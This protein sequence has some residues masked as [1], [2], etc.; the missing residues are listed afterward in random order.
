MQTK[1][2]FCSKLV[3]LSVLPRFCYFLQYLNAMAS[4]TLEM[5]RKVSFSVLERE[6]ENE[7]KQLN[8]KKQTKRLL[9]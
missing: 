4:L 9:L 6:N 8:K 1:K 7:T 2:N 5:I 3:F